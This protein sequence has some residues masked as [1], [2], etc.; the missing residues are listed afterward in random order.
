M[1]FRQFFCAVQLST[2][3]TESTH[4]RRNDCAIEGRLLG[5]VD[6]D[7]APPD[8]Q[9]EGGYLYPLKCGVHL[10]VGPTQSSPYVIPSFKFWF[11]CSKL[12]RCTNTVTTQDN[13]PAKIAAAPVALSTEQSGS[14]VTRG[15][16]AIK[17]RQHEPVSIPEVEPGLLIYEA[18]DAGRANFS[19]WWDVAIALRH[20]PEA[21]AAAKGV[22]Q[23]WKSAFRFSGMALANYR[24][25]LQL[26]ANPSLSPEAVD[27]AKLIGQSWLAAT[28][29]QQQLT[30]VTPDQIKCLSPEGVELAMRLIRN[31][32]YYDE[33]VTQKHAKAMELW[34]KATE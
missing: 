11:A 12:R 18:L 13:L 4:S 17:A 24:E 30:V 15:L 16:E 8:L 9:N 3:S 27:V 14:L 34:R 6:I 22:A 26:A 1:P 19:K 7:I 25:L 21:S 10:N 31:Q 23:I 2:F 29:G 32:K 5:K 28:Q 33:H 20:L